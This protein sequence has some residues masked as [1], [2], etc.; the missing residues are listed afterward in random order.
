MD[1]FIYFILLHSVEGF[2]EFIN[3]VIRWGLVLH[4]VPIP[5]L[6]TNHLHIWEIF[7]QNHLEGSKHPIDDP[8]A[9]MF[10]TEQISYYDRWPFVVGIML[11]PHEYEPLFPKIG[12]TLWQS[13]FPYFDQ[14][15]FLPAWDNLSYG[16]QKTRCYLHIF[17]L[18]IRECRVLGDCDAT[19]VAA[20]ERDPR[21]ALF[22]AKICFIAMAVRYNS[23]D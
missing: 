4:K 5:W 14:L 8:E 17:L 2:F 21:Q 11:V 19:S 3:F 13:S 10:R 7:F 16:A 15:R 23:L 9:W 20:I 12:F 6:R 18:E 1:Y 22:F